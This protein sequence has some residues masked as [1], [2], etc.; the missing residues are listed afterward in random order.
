MTQTEFF[1]YLAPIALISLTLHEYSH[2]YVAY[3]LG[4]DTAKRRG[5]LSFNPLRHLDPIGT[6]FIIFFHFGWAKPVPVDPR[7]F[8]DPRK[9]MMF[10]ALAGPAANLMIALV[11]GF[12]LRMVFKDVENYVGLF[13]F[14]CVVV[15]INVILALFNL[16]P[17]FPLDGSSILKGL[18]PSTWA[19]RLANVDKYFAILLIGI[20]IADGFL[21]IGIFGGILLKPVM[22][23]VQ[24]L[25]Q[26]A[27]PAFLSRL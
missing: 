19:D 6:L 27:F 4:D 1:I 7:N 16:L 2:G 20:F 21:K 5:R 22:F 13:D 18:L 10:V 26:E 9:H 14:F 24:F 23:V 25:T 8:S 3:L 12:L 15:L 11:G 17:F